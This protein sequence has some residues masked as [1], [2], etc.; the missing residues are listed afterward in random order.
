M[1]FRSRYC[2]DQARIERSRIRTLPSHFEMVTEMA[3]VLQ[4]CPCALPWL[5]LPSLIEEFLRYAFYQCLHDAYTHEYAAQRARRCAQSLPHDG[6]LI[7]TSCGRRWTSVGNPCSSSNH[8]P[9]RTVR[10][11]YRHIRADVLTMYALLKIIRTSARNWSQVMR[12]ARKRASKPL[13]PPK[14]HSRFW[15]RSVRASRTHR[16]PHRTA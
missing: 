2:N 10:R 8:W 14:K 9:R 15:R 13:L 16:H 12:S 1:S 7:Q 6:R 5:Q 3:R 4:S 11:W